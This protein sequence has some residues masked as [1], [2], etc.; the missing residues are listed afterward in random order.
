MGKT[1]PEY[2]NYEVIKR[3]Y[4]RDIDSNAVLLRHVKSGARV[5]LLPNKDN[6][7]V[8]F[9]GFRTRPS[10]STG[11]AHI[12]EHTVL[13]GSR[14]FPVKDPFIE[15]AKGSLN[16]FLNAMTYPDKTVY[17][18]ASCN[19][20]DFKNL[21]H[22][23][24]DAVFFPRIY[25]EKRI[26]EQEG[27]HYERDPKGGDLR[28]NGVVYNEMKGVMS[29]PDDVLER[30]ITA[31]LFPHTTYAVESGGD[32]EVIP[33]LT[34]EQY[35]DFHR[36]FYHPSNSYIY[37]YGDADMQERL[38]WMDENYLSKFDFRDPDSAIVREKPFTEPSETEQPYSLMEGEEE[39]G[40]AFLAWNVALPDGLDEKRNIAFRV[41]DYVLCDAPGAPLKE[42]LL[43]SGIGRDICSSFDDGLAQPVW[44]VIA[45]YTDAEKKEEFAAVIDR[46]LREIAEKGFE[47][48][49]LL[50]GINYHEFRYR[51]ADFGSY[52][53]G[54]VYGLSCMESWLYDDSQPWLGL[55]DGDIFEEL[56]KEA[57]NG[58]FEHT[59]R[60]MVLENSHR[61][62]VILKP[63]PGLA[64]KC[65]NAQHEKLQQYKAGLTAAQLKE[66]D[67]ETESLRTYQEAA[68]DPEAIARIPL[69]TR[70]DLD[71][72]A[73]RFSTKVRKIGKETE[74]L[75]H[76]S[77][78]NGI[79]YLSFE[80]DIR[81]LPQEYYD[82][83]T[84]LKTVFG[85]VGTEHYTYA[86]LNNR[87]NILTGG[88]EPAVAGYTDVRDSS[89]YRLMFEVNVK[90]LRENVGAALELLEEILLRSD[91]SDIKRLRDL[92]EEERSGLREDL[93]EGGHITASV[94]AESYFSEAAC[95]RD[96][97]GGIE[98]YR[99]IS[100][101]LDKPERLRK[102]PETL[103][104]M[105][106]WIFSGM[107]LSA[108]DVTGDEKDLETAA[109]TAGAFRA[110]L[111]DADNTACGDP[112]LQPYTIH[113]E[114]RNEGFTTAGQVQY[115]CRAGN[116]AGKGL[117]Y[118]GA[119]RVLR[120]I[121]GY[122][123]LW[124]RIRVKGGAYGCM[125]SFG[126]DGTS[127]FVTYRD[128]HVR[129]SVQTFEEAPAWL[130]NFDADSRSMTQYVI[131]AVSALDTP[132]TPRQFGRYC[133]T[134]YMTGLTQE[135]VQEE[136]DQ[137]L[138]CETKDVQALAAY[139]KAMLDSGCI[140]VV[141]TRAKIE[142][143]KELFGSVARLF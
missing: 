16:T 51:E 43:H 65:E 119:L 90:V 105:S 76:P 56:K 35:L 92:L 21:M 132:M 81:K 87:V 131:G 106:A 61:S 142:K 100:G 30:E 75:A 37:L 11:V 46:T 135:M 137:V 64:E 10:D 143:N 48:E 113:P 80:F 124:N 125:S 134:G 1:D 13:C 34:Y 116:F 28:V 88:I 86:Q 82:C 47:K 19:D 128:P 57:E 136:R 2:R 117:P 68:D 24:L 38:A 114:K 4:L 69:L 5:V 49:A 109:K 95:I 141:G 7:K 101:I 62:L 9:I 126:R 42:A 74:L 71:K 127:C 22:V 55:R 84:V 26:F 118:T 39:N 104:K 60:Q 15:L 133:L 98:S 18:V 120:V 52:P 103:R 14:D 45:K 121:M 53:K 97:M 54:L 94:R 140:C 58:L 63:V 36:R 50:A 139:V 27:W 59:L 25:E 110:A 67:A 29:S 108:V 70:D 33:S 20:R 31:S 130:E 93:Q 107:R 79:L 111:P 123:Y 44:S 91:Y 78:A 23:Y 99:T 89:S 6:N 40:R 96:A 85:M 77:F 73:V 102:L 138:T 122:D 41:L 32:P 112:S 3:E 83:L 17:P 129:E 12:I 115:V 66:I 8:F 72:K